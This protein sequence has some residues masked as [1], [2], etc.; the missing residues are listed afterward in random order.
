MKLLSADMHVKFHITVFSF[1][2]T[3]GSKGN[4]DATSRIR[5]FA[6]FA[7][8]EFLQCSFSH[9]SSRQKRRKLLL[10]E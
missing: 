6:F 10:D 4:T 7:S 3:M 8:T 1:G 9:L 2:C 5:I